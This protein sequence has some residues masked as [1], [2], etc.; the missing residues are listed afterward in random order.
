M[1]LQFTK[2][3]GLGNDFVVVNAT[4][5][6]QTFSS[7]NIQLLANRR[8]GIGFDQLLV[9]EPSSDSKHDFR[10]RIFNADGREVEQCGNGARCVGHYI[11]SEGLTDKK[12]I[13]LRTIAGEI[14][15]TQEA[16]GQ[17]TVNM[18]P[19]SFKLE[20]IPFVAPS[21]ET[22]YQLSVAGSPILF[23][24]VSMGNPHAVIA[25]GD[26]SCALVQEI[27]QAFQHS[28]AFPNQVNVGFMEVVSPEFIRL[29]VFERG[30]G[31]TQ[32]CGSGACA[33]VVIGRLN[34]HLSERVTVELPGGKL[35]VFWRSRDHD[36][37]LTGPAQ[38][39]F[40]GETSLI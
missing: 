11:F 3:H 9:I 2:M 4:Q 10:Y 8:T 39:V 17:I 20:T 18:G 14:V 26:V 21:G 19:P 24:V 16:D 5:T 6:N 34:H 40:Q 36:V 25:V 12:T 33:A 15:L 28:S 30:V 38:I 35:T 13:N 37:Y 27:G 31:E 7:A 29:R 22:P 32:A 1:A 23:G